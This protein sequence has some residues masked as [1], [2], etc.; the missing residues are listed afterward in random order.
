MKP[1]D[2]SLESGPR[3]S[4]V[5]SIRSGKEYIIPEDA[6]PSGTLAPGITIR[7]FASNQCGARGMNTSTATFDPG[8]EL[9][10][11][12][13]D[14]SE[15]ATVL[16]GEAVISVEGRIYKLGPF[17]CIHLPA[18]LAHRVTNPSSEST[19][20]IHTAFAS[21]T[22]LREFVSDD[23]TDQELAKDSADHKY[24]EHFAEI[25]TEPPY[26]LAPYTRFFDLF[27]GRFGAVGI[28]GGYGEFKPG[29]SLPCHFHEYDESIT[30]V[31]GEAICEVMGRRYQLGRYDTAV[32]PQG[33]PHRFLNM[34]GEIMAIIWVYAGSEPSRTLA[35][36]RYCRGLWKW[37]G[38][39]K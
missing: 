36:A 3:I 16:E 25:A 9:S 31:K 21:P 33:L 7:E 4:S 6:K 20:I 11:H 34:S 30:I 22:P 1:P 18:G 26:R 38:Q 35:N 28:C 8:V 12:K 19:A 29:S 23:F 15:A 2:S 37:K 14:V 27:G 32:V 39:V 10:Y 5:V 24:P 13:H 17:D